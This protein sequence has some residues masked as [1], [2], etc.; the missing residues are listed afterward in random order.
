M[1]VCNWIIYSRTLVPLNKISLNLYVYVFNVQI[2]MPPSDLECHEIVIVAHAA[3]QDSLAHSVRFQVADSQG[4]WNPVSLL[5]YVAPKPC[6]RFYINHFC[7][8]KPRIV[9][10][11]GIL[12][13]CCMQ[14]HVYTSHKITCGHQ[15]LYLKV[16]DFC[17]HRWKQNGSCVR[18]TM[19][20]LWCRV[21]EVLPL[22]RRWKHWQ[23][24][25]FTICFGQKKFWIV[26]TWLYDKPTNSIDGGKWKLLV[27]V[28][29][30][31]MKKGRWR[32]DCPY[33][34]MQM[35]WD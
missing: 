2:N 16:T 14:T 19:H 17:G 7:V 11:S 15:H 21:H 24:F 1:D 3:L 30:M 27:G 26:W 12:L 8:H 28:D 29:R 18:Y 5:V 20:S 13:L 35:R 4:N 9:I 31:T 25:C 22:L 6:L 34:I 10:K 33:M 23:I 32:G